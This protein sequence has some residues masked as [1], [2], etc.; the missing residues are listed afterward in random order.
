MAI[1]DSNTKWRQGHML[2]AQAALD[3]NLANRVDASQTLAIV[4]SHDCDLAQPIDSEPVVEIIV[5]RKIPTANGNYAFAKSVR[6]LHL[7]CTQAATSNIIE[8][9]ATD[10]V[11]VPKEALQNYEPDPGILLSYEELVIL[12]RW[13]ATRYHR[14]AFPN[15]FNNRLRDTGVE[16]ILKDVSKKFGVHLRTIFFDVD[17]GKEVERSGTADTY[18]LNVVLLYDTDNDAAVA[19]ANAEE[20]RK[21]IIK[22]FEE[23]CCKNLIWENIELQSCEVMSDQ[24]ITYRQA[25]SFKEWRS[26]NVSLKSKPPQPSLVR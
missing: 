10:K 15:E 1:W 17:E 6:T 11:S 18:S 24:A 12:Q 8:I 2:P 26:E 20:A 16:K 5:G 9:V 7:N 21:L 14:S 3:L 25:L 4:V 13:L 19:E 23:K 22:A